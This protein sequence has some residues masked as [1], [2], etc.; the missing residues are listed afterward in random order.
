MPVWTDC[1][2]QG[3]ANYGDASVRGWHVGAPP[4]CLRESRRG[5]ELGQPLAEGQALQPLRPRA[6]CVHPPPSLERDLFTPLTLLEL[7]G[8]GEV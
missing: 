5:A 4:R 7:R 1:D 6:R 3:P 8:G 2:S